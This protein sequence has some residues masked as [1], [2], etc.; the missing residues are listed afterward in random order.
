MFKTV[1]F[2]LEENVILNDFA[3]LLLLRSQSTAVYLGLIVITFQE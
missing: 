2:E 1:R 3:L